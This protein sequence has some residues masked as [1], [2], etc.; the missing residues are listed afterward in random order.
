MSGRHPFSELT[1]DFSPERRSRID[2][3]KAELLAQRPMNIFE[4]IGKVTS[5]IER[6]HSQFLADALCESLNGDRSLFEAFWKLV[7]PCY[8]KVPESPGQVE[9]STEEEVVGGKVDICI[10]SLVAPKRVIGIEVKTVEDSTERGQLRRYYEGLEEKYQGSEVQMAYLTPFSRERAGD[11]AAS[12]PTVLE[13]DQFKD[14]HPVAR[15]VSWLDLES[16]P[17]DGNALWEQ[18]RAYVLE[19]I[20]SKDKLQ[21]RVERDRDIT[22]FF[23]AAPAERFWEEVGD[24][25]ISHEGRWATIDLAKQRND[26]LV[27][28]SLVGAF[29]ALL[30][31]DNVVPRERNDKFPS[32]LRQPFLRSPHREVHEALFNLAEVFD[33]VWV[34]GK[35]DY[36][37]RTAHKDFHSGVSLVTS[38]GP[39]QLLIWLMR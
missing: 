5:G 12:L 28:K 13:F 1:K 11:R 32:K 30:H 26:S 23:G 19:H 15:H 21:P 4:T 29:K 9:L 17:W 10:R 35:R 20:S 8:W 34:E 18:H 14:S 22:Y 3:M 33:Y 24:L 36:G 25:D 37:I 7:A 38:D 6:F 39:G 27:A 2:S 31:S 16:I